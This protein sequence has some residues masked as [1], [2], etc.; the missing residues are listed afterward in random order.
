MKTHSQPRYSGYYTGRVLWSKEQQWGH[1]EFGSSSSLLTSE[2]EGGAFRKNHKLY[3]TVGGGTSR[4]IVRTDGAPRY[5]GCDVVGHVSFIPAERQNQGWYRGGVLECLSLEIPQDWI[6]KCL[7]GREASRV[8]F[9]PVTNRFDPLIFH[10]M[11]ALQEEAEV[12]GPAGRLFAETTATLLALH[13]VR[14]YSNLAA[15]IP[16]PHPIATADLERTIEFI[17]AYLGAELTLE[18]LAK[19]ANMPVSSF[20]RNFR[21]ATRVSPHKYVVLRRIERSKQLLRS[22]DISIVEI[23]YLL[24]FSSQSH[25]STVFKNCIGESPARFRACFRRT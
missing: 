1:L 19:I 25:F 4:T 17:D 20:V 5:D 6:T 18:Q 23:A 7:N 12:G 10:A 16:S 14:R 9:L 21:S 2:A 15:V 24:G 11:T 8:E 22:S 3:V 13:L